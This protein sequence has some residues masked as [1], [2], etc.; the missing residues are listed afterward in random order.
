MGYPMQVSYH[1]QTKAERRLQHKKRKRKTRTL[2]YRNPYNMEAIIQLMRVV[3]R[4]LRL[5][6]VLVNLAQ[7]ARGPIAATGGDAREVPPAQE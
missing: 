6:E 7:R 4:A 3:E 1:C 5:I 2:L